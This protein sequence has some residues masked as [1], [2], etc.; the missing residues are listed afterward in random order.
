M[1]RMYNQ[2]GTLYKGILD[3]LVKTVTTE[4]ILGVYKGYIAHLARIL[5]HTVSQQRLPFVIELRGLHH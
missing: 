5:P 4:G 2:T 3:C 1:S